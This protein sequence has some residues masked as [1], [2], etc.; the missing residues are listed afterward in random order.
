PNVSERA[1]ER[2]KQRQFE[3]GEM[4]PEPDFLLQGQLSN[5]R[6]VAG[7]V[8]EYTFYFSLKLVDLRTGEQVWGRQTQISKQGTKASVGF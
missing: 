5:V 2:A 7:N 1:T 6:R 3:T 4:P 8:K